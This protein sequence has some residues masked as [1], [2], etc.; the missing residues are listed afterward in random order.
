MV[1]FPYYS[2]TIPISLGILMGVVWE[3]YG[4]GL[5]IL[6]FPENSIDDNP[7]AGG[8]GGGVLLGFQLSEFTG[9]NS[10]TLR[11]LFFRNLSFGLWKTCHLGWFIL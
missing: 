1:S 2:H 6:G 5:P 4:K 9:A 8:I 10:L 11:Y 7:L 3:S